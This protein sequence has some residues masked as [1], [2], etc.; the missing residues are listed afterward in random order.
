MKPAIRALFLLAPASFV[1]F[2]ADTYQKPPKAIEDI[3][4]SPTTPTLSLSPN[5]A[6]AMQG[7]PVRYPPIAE[8]S[9][10]MLR[11]GRHS[12]QSRRPTGC[13]TPRSNR[14][15]CCARFR[16]ARRSRSRCRRIRS[17]SIGALE[18]GWQP[19]RLHQLHAGRHR[20]LDRR[21]ATGARTGCPT[22]ASTKYSAEAAAAA[23][24]ARRRRW[25]S[26]AMDGRRQIAAGARGARQSRRAA[27]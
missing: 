27:A 23:A 10:P 20:D 18:S 26:G 19:F 25:R 4:N 3:L 6:Y 9:E 14:T 5:R 15:C 16:K 7:S 22:C 21:Y 24:A 12:H 1:F 8:L 11:L 17:W 13:T 2:G